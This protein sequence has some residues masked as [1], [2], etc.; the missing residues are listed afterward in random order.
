[1][2]PAK[3]EHTLGEWRFTFEEGGLSSTA[4]IE[5]IAQ[6]ANLFRPPNIIFGKNYC[7]IEHARPFSLRFDSREALKYIN[8]ETREKTFYSSTQEP[9]PNGISYIP[10]KLQIKHAEKWKAMEVSDKIEITQIN[11][12]SDSFFVTPFKGLVGGNFKIERVEE[13][14]IPVH[15]LG[16]ENEIKFYKQGSFYEDELDDN[17]LIQYEYKF[18]AM[19]SSW[20]ALIRC[21]VRVDDVVIIILDTRLYWE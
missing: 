14:V 8:Y 19:A 20:F 5:N 11:E 13:S 1:M 21:Y 17:G 12:S 15:K 9:V 4:D 18:R 10:P 16:P 6:N 2:Q 3:T 7:L